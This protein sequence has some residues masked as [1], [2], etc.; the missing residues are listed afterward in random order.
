MVDK[1]SPVPLCWRCPSHEQHSWAHLRF[2]RDHR[3]R[4][5]VNSGPKNSHHHGKSSQ[6]SAWFQMLFPRE[7]DALLSRCDFMFIRANS[8]GELGIHHNLQRATGS[9]NSWVDHANTLKTK[10]KRILSLH[11]YPGQGAPPRFPWESSDIHGVY[12]L[13]LAFSTRLPSSPL[14]QTMS[15]K[16]CIINCVKLSFFFIF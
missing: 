2:R 10:R 15:L 1:N 7:D 14:R 4:T 11:K 13:A 9:M 6:K 16:W 12:T 8:W 3:W 5:S